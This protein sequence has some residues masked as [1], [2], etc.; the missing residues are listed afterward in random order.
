MPPIEQDRVLGI[1]AGGPRAA[2]VAA[3]LLFPHHGGRV[4]IAAPDRETHERISSVAE[5][6]GMKVWGEPGLKDQLPFLA[7]VDVLYI[8]ADWTDGP[9][10]DGDAKH[11][12][13]LLRLAALAESVG[14]P[15]VWFDACGRTPP[16]LR[17]QIEASG[18]LKDVAD[19]RE[20]ARAATRTLKRIR[21]A[22]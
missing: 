1:A 9:R 22:S 8:I 13:S 4:V 16:T 10:W 3:S 12:R 5:E 11:E 20:E 15:M 6:R 17:R 2:S 14:V 19:S 21:L 7:R 18:V